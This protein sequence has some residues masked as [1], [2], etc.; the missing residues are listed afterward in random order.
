[1]KKS[2][3]IL[4]ASAIL[5]MVG[6][7]PKS[8]E[9]EIGKVYQ[10]S[11]EEVKSNNETVMTTF[12]QTAMPTTGK[13]IVVME[14][15]MGTI[16]IQLFPEYAPKTVENFIGLIENGYYDGLIFH[17][18]MLDFMIQGGDPL[19][20]G[21]GGESLWGGKFEDEFSPNLKNLRGALSMANSGPNSNGSQFFIVQKEGG[22]SW[23]D[24]KHTVFGQ[25]FEGMDIVDAIANVETD[26]F[27]KP[28]TDVVM[29]KLSL[30]TF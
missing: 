2:F 16:K 1:M 13:Q 26:G 25:V 22:T 11:P 24:G 27:D 29:E 3:S 20:T 9:A 10:G 23:L 6:C 15:S 19:G 28:L 18:V 7:T 12:D 5:L 14:T 8:P 4:F 17:R 21:R 30:Q